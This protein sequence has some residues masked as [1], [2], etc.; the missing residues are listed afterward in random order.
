MGFPD[1]RA[2]LEFAKNLRY[3]SG[4]VSSFAKKGGN[5]GKQYKGTPGNNQAQTNR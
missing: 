4:I 1:F 5:I 2:G 3:G